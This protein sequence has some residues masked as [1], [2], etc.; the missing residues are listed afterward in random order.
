[1]ANYDSSMGA[2]F[3]N[4][5]Y[6]SK[7]Q[8]SSALRMAAIDGIWHDIL[9]YRSAFTTNLNLTSV[10]HAAFQLVQT[11]YVSNL[12]NSFEAAL[13]ELV[14]KSAA[15]N[16]ENQHHRLQLLTR[17]KILASIQKKYEIPNLDENYLMRIIAGVVSAL[18]PMEMVFSRYLQALNYL[19][20]NYELPT[21]L[22]FTATLYTKISGI[23]ELSR[24]Y[25]VDDLED[26]QKKILVNPD[27]KIASPANI[28]GLMEQLYA[29]VELP[30]VSKVIK[31]LVSIFF[32]IQVNPF[33]TYSEE[34]SILFCKAVLAHLKL[35]PMVVNVNIEKLLPYNEETQNVIKEVNRTNDITYF[36]VHA[37]DVLL[38]E[39]AEMSNLVEQAKIVHIENEQY[40]LDTESSSD[41]HHVAEES[42]D[43]I[44]AEPPLVKPVS[45]ANSELTLTKDTAISQFSVG[46]SDRDALLLKQHLIESDPNLKKNEAHF[47][48]FHCT[49]GKFY[50]IDQ[51]KKSLNTVYET[52]RRAMD[53]LVSLGYYRKEM[54]K[55]KYI[56]TPIRRKGMEN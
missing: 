54:V 32:I 35:G 48:A 28:E 51:F 12:I 45:E 34:M 39:I 17:T 37:I 19:D 36:I 47:Y 14:L 7:A 56:Y 24:L 4:E 13:N 42:P 26:P 20:D 46:F 43:S 23:R 53:N 22:D 40:R 11:P 18:T 1:M 31:A 6:A 5:R 30:Q 55:N 50:T 3:S 49:M 52:A 8:V 2:R 15:L 33:D 9:E 16:S 21:D 41:E 29:F 44:D 38:P 27:I 25:R 10:S